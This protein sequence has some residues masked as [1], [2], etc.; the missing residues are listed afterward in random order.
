MENILVSLEKQYDNI[1]GQNQI[2]IDELI[3]SRQREMTVRKLLSN[4][5]DE[6]IQS[7][8]RLQVFED[9]GEDFED[10]GKLSPL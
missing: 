5:R 10:Y 1:V 4:F 6:R 2:L 7:L 3:K 9:K 8:D